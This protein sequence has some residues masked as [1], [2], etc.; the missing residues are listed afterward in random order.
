MQIRAD[1]VMKSLFV[2]EQLEVQILFSCQSE[3]VFR[4]STESVMRDLN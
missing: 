2:L 3:F 4:A 1:C